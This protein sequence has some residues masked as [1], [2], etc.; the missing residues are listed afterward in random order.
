MTKRHSNTPHRTDSPTEEIRKEAEE[1]A[2]RVTPDEENEERRGEAADTL[3]PN[4]QAQEQAQ[5]DDAS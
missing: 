5:G 3:T 4:P 1:A 2:A